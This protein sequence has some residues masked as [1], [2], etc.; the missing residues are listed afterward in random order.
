MGRIVLFFEAVQNHFFVSSR[1]TKS[2]RVQYY[3]IF[4]HSK[5]RFDFRFIDLRWEVD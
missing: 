1:K 3:Y 2:F 5:K 4:E